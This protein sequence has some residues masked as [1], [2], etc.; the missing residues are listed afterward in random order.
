MLTWKLPAE[1]STLIS[2]DSYYRDITKVS[3][4][5]RNNWNFD[6][7]EALDRS[8]LIE[9]ANALARGEAIEKPVYLFP[10]HTRAP[11]GER[12]EPCRFIIIEGL[13]AFY[14]EE[15][16]DLMHTRVFIDTPDQVGFERRLERD[17]RERSCTSDEV[18]LQ[19]VSEVRPMY[20][21]N[22]KPTRSFADLV[23]DGEDTLED[24]ADV[25]IKHILEGGV[26]TED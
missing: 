18:V 12:I 15:L 22:I 5:E 20:E 19:F 3:D 9:Q 4:E 13:Y 25:V 2:L 6:V 16:R 23:L 26:M 14:W 10:S 21:R 11:R 24:S 7:P 1:K 17:I 8:L